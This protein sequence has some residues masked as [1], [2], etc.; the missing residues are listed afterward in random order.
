MTK[1]PRA[2]VL[3]ELARNLPL[4]HQSLFAHRHPQDTPPF[5]W[6]M[7]TDWHSPHPR[8]ATQ[9]FRGAAKSSIGEEGLLIGA[10]FKM[11][12]NALVLGDTTERA[13]DRLRAI[14]HEI[15]SNEAVTATFGNLI[16][17]TWQETK[18][19]LSNGVILQSYGRGQ[20]LRGVKHNDIRPDFCLGDDIE[21]EESCTNEEQIGKT[22]KW[23]LAV[24]IPALDIEAKIRIFGTPLHPRAMI[25]QLAADPTWLSRIYPIEYIDE[26]TQEKRSSWPSRYPMK[27]IN[28]KRESY[29]RHGH[30]NHF[31]QEYLCK[32]EDP[33]QKTFLPGMFQVEQTVRTWQPC[34]AMF[35]PARTVKESSASTGLAVWSWIGRRM[36]VWEARPG[37]WKPDEIV[38]EI[39]KIDEE[40]RPIVI[41]VEKDGLEEFI[42]QP[43]RHEQLRRGY[44]VPIRDMRAPRGKIDFVRALQPL[45]KAK[46]IVFAKA[47]PDAF[48]QFLQFPSGRIDVPNA[49]AY[50]YMLRPGQ[51]VYD[52]FSA[53]H[54][55]EDL[56]LVG[57]HP[58]YLAVNSN[59]QVTT[60]VLIQMFDGGLCILA[61][62]VRE[63][64]PGNNL[65][66]IMR[67][68]GLA[69]GGR[70][71]VFAP[72][73][74]FTAYD[75]IGLKAAARAVPLELGHGGNEAS[76]RE[77]IRMMLNRM[78]RGR[79][80]VIIS[81]AARWT[82]NAFAGGYAR[83]VTKHGTLTD[84]AV[85]GPYRVL[86]E[87]LES[88]AALTKSSSLRDDEELN[89]QYTSDGRRFV[90][91]RA[92]VNR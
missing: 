54:V 73:R 28:D 16:G 42:M 72:K 50:A 58:V 71:K 11:F 6:S 86:M 66:P 9:A 29:A 15:E 92:T 25:C 26:K 83:E 2:E 14:K 62:W 65:D 20:S 76:G 90:S 37:L 35:D 44:S 64:D 81:T 67:E 13:A 38:N 43:L 56:P 7:I 87:G 1:D 5:H 49:L 59:G 84:Q 70:P 78:S 51:P 91:A 41:G 53:Q 61:D 8:V 74:H 80:A 45:F 75:L 89:Y 79:P 60:G 55:I 18:I 32:A 68:A 69:G 22:M 57:R 88:L 63:G 19:I 27:W 23:L 4:A 10:G 85:D 34:Y 77:E 52:G 36:I 48:A 31:S 33:A 12:R 82:L 3:A 46:D 39:F 21:N 30:F 24:V 17:R 47:C 40:Y